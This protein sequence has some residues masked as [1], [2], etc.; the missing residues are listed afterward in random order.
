MIKKLMK[1][2]EELL[3]KESNNEIIIADL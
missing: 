2:I 1:I 3:S